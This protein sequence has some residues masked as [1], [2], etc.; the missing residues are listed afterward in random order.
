M[1]VQLFAILALLGLGPVALAAEPETP[2]TADSTPGGNGFLQSP[3]VAPSPVT[4][5]AVEPDITIRSEGEELIYEYRVKGQLYMIKI[6]PQFGPPYFLID[7][8]GDGVMDIRNSD[9][10]DISIPQWVLFTWD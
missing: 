3:Q 8:N 5:D 10:R 7:T 1:N 4:G 9:P 6:Q 2:P